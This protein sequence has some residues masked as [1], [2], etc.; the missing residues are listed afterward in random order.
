MRVMIQFLYVSMADSA[1]VPGSVLSLWCQY[2]NCTVSVGSN[3]CYQDNG[4]YRNCKKY[5][6]FIR[7]V[8]TLSGQQTNVV[9]AAI[10]LSL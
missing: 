5:V 6:P 3:H 7:F 8:R 4:M 2:I 9:K 10:K 1:D